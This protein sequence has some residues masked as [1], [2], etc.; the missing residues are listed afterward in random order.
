MIKRVLKKK[1]IVQDAPIVLRFIPAIEMEE[2][3]NYVSIS[4]TSVIQRRDVKPYEGVDTGLKALM[5]TVVWCSG[6]STLGDQHSIPMKGHMPV[7]CDMV[8]LE[9]EIM[10]SY[11][12]YQGQVADN[13]KKN[14]AAK[15]PKLDASGEVIVKKPRGEVDPVSGCS[16]G[17]QGHVLGLL[18]LAN[19]CS[20]T[21]RGVCITAMTACL[22]KDYGLEEKKAKALSSSWYSTLWIRKPAFYQ[23]KW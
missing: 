11:K 9:K 12:V 14:T 18:M 4:G 1:V 8:D 13:L 23:K 6:Y 19:K 15:T 3:I 2:G 5:Q 20:L 16:T 22:M 17:S 21:N 7:L 10:H